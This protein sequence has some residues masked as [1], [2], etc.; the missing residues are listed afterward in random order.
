MTP[1]RLTSRQVSMDLR[2]DLQTFICKWFS[3]SV[4]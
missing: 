1:R 3:I 2:S 4:L